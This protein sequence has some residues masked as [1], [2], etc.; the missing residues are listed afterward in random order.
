[1]THRFIAVASFSDLLQ[2]EQA[3]L[4]L[5][6]EGID[7][8]LEGDAAAPVV[9]L[10][11]VG[12]E[13]YRVLAIETET[14]AARLALAPLLGPRPPRD[15]FFDDV[16]RH[17][18]LAC[19]CPMHEDEDAC[20]ACDWSFRVSAAAD[21]PES[22]GTSNVETAAV[23]GLLAEPTPSVHRGFIVVT[24]I[25]LGALLWLILVQSLS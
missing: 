14:I 10:A 18:C 1:M 16:E 9:S 19:G 3:C 15:R 12:R 6:L 2:A 13:E 25:I 17:A 23:G 21:D 22:S 20:Q 11:A 8:R 7:C 5:R 24:A 4:Y